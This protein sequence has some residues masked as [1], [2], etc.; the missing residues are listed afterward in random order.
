V[1]TEPTLAYESDPL[2]SGRYAVQ[3]V[4]EAA[5]P[6]DSPSAASA[7]ASRGDPVRTT[8][9]AAAYCSPSD[10]RTPLRAA[11]PI[12]VAATTNPTPRTTA[13]PAAM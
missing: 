10:A 8:T 12:D 6:S 2:S 5:T 13:I 11:E 9:S 1:A 4:A 7:R 3:P